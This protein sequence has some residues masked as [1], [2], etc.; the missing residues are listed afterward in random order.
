MS[1]SSAAYSVARSTRHLLERDAIGA[2]ARH[3]VV[4]DRLDVQVPPREVVHVVRL[5]R[6]EHVRLEQRVVRDAAE[7]EA[8]VGK[9]VLV[10]LQI[11]AELLLR[12]IGEPRREARAASRA[13][14]SCARHAGVAMVERDVARAPGR[15]RQRDA[16]RCA[17][18][19]GSRLD[20]LGVERRDL[21][22]VDLVEPARERGLVQHHLVVRSPAARGGVATG[23]VVAR[24]VPAAARVVGRRRAWRSRRRRRARRRLPWIPSATA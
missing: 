13:R 16:R 22:A 5:V 21:G 11:L 2:L 19:C 10:V 12:R 23:V 6:L 24:R 7:R 3:V 18:A 8:F 20:R 15:D 14:S 9:R 1:A 17:P 4:R